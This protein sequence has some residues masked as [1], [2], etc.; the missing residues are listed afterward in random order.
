MEPIG[1]DR[2]EIGVRSHRRGVDW[3]LLRSMGIFLFYFHSVGASNVW[4][5]AALHFLVQTVTEHAAGTS[6]AL[7]RF[8]FDGAFHF[9][10]FF[11]P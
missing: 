4:T 8:R 3:R 1:R 2:E 6:L 11:E 7:L 5:R 9:E 10:T